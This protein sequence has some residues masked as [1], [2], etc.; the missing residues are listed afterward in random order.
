MKHGS[1]FKQPDR[2]TVTA[3]MTA[4]N[5]TVSRL[6]TRNGNMGHKQSTWTIF[7]PDLFNDLHTEAINFHG[8]VRPN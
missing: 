8:T 6:S 1:V 7:C 2:K 4:V 5:A 3:T